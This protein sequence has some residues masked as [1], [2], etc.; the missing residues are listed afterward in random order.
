VDEVTAMGTS[1]ATLV[2][3]TTAPATHA[4]HSAATPLGRLV[5]LG[6]KVAD[7]CALFASAVELSRA[8]QTEPPR[9]QRERA[10]AWWIDSA[11]R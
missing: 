2:H 8:L 10:Q 7:A 3:P 4:E 5:A 9:R 11:S 6:N 1:T